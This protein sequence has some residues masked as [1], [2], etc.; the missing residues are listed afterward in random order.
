MGWEVMTLVY[1]CNGRKIRIY[2]T[3]DLR[4]YLGTGMAT[5]RGIWCFIPAEKFKLPAALGDNLGR[6]VDNSGVLEQVQMFENK[7]DL[8]Q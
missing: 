2:R 1:E 4:T 5:S 8:P 7:G 6:A 3:M